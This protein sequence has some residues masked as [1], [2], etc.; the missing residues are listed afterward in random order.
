MKD[1]VSDLLDHMKALIFMIKFAMFLIDFHS[2]MSLFLFYELL[3]YKF[4]CYFC[5]MSYVY[6]NFTFHIKAFSLGIHEIFFMYI[7]S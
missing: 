2:C 4:C 7:F 3:L 1:V 5:F 6:T